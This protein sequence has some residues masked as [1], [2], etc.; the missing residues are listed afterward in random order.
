VIPS[1]A[2]PRRHRIVSAVKAFAVL[3][4]ATL[5]GVTVSNAQIAGRSPAA[6]AK[7][8]TGWTLHNPAKNI[9]SAPAPGREYT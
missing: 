6:A 7:R 8:L 1:R 3:T 2:A 5:A 9:W 4:V